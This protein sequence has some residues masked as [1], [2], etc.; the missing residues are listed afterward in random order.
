MIVTLSTRD[1]KMWN[2]KTSEQ[3]TEKIYS[4]YISKNIF[5]QVLMLVLCSVN[6][7]KNEEWKNSRQDTEMLYSEDIKQNISLSI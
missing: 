1:L 5:S 7:F 4:E 6:K 2:K 3:D